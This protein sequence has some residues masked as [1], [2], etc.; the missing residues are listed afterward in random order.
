MNWLDAVPVALGSFAVLAG[1]WYA[2]SAHAGRASAM[3]TG[4]QTAHRLAQCNSELQRSQGLL[5]EMTAL[6]RSLET[7]LRDVEDPPVTREELKALARA[8]AAA[9]AERDALRVEVE[10]YRPQAMA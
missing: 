6:A 2:R 3:A 1:A 9:R 7:K 10:K 5:S 8:L 4:E